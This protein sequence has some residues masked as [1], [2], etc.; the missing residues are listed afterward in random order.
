MTA[1]ENREGRDLTCQWCSHP[2][3]EAAFQ[4]QH[5]RMCLQR[6]PHAMCFACHKEKP[7]SAMCDDCH[8]FATQ[9][10]VDRVREAMADK[11]I[12]AHGHGQES[13][14]QRIAELE[15]ERDEMKR[16][17]NDYRAQ[18][19][20][21]HRDMMIVRDQRDAYKQT[22]EQIHSDDR[23]ARRRARIAEAA[24]K[25]I[26]EI[27]KREY[28]AREDEED[29]PATICSLCAMGLDD[30]DED[31]MVGIAIAVVGDEVMGT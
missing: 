12:E 15:A 28:Q 2:F 18:A 30:H 1:Q 21:Y 10:N 4:V 31:C 13:A 8:G 11:V 16:L 27:A 24:L 9:V 25:R 26:L 7:V 19:H 14:A 5:E 29:G 22:A 20:L 3:N 6:P 23:P 17:A